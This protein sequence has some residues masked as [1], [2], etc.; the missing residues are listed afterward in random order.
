MY[1]AALAV[2]DQRRTLLCP[3]HVSIFMLHTQW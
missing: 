3:V 2:L 1:G